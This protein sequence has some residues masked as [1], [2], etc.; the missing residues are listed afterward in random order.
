MVAAFDD[1]REWLLEDPFDGGRWFGLGVGRNGCFAGVGLMGV[2]MELV[3]VGGWDCVVVV[4]EL[5]IK[6]GVSE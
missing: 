5:L 1:G 6:T 3:V 4:V 2:A